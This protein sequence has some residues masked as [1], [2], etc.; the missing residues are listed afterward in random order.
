MRIGGIVATGMSNFCRWLHEWNKK[1]KAVGKAAIGLKELAWKMKWL[2]YI[3][4]ERY[5][6][7]WQWRLIQTREERR[8]WHYLEDG[9]KRFGRS[10]SQAEIEKIS[11]YE[12]RYTEFRV[13]FM[14]SH[15]TIAGLCMDY[16]FF[17]E[18]STHDD[19]HVCRLLFHDGEFD[20][21]T[22]PNM[23]LSSKF[24]EMFET[25]TRDN[26]SFWYEC[27]KGN[28]ERVIIE[29]SFTYQRRQYEE[30]YQ[31]MM[32]GKE[33]LHK[34]MFSFSKEEEIKGQE[35]LEKLGIQEPYICIFARDARY[36]ATRYKEVTWEQD[37]LDLRN[38][39]INTLKKMTQ[40]FWN[41]GIQS[42]RMGAMM[43]TTY[44]CKGAVDYT[45]VGRTEFLDAYVFSKC[46]FFIGDASGLVALPMFFKKPIGLINLQVAIYHYDNLAPM[47]IGIFLK[48]YDPIR[49]CYLR[50]KEWGV[51]FRN[52]VISNM[53]FNSYM[54]QH[55][56][57]VK[58]SS[59][60]ILDIAKELEAIHNRTMQYTEHD[61]KLQ[62]R[63]RDIVKGFQSM[64]P[65]LVN[66]YPGRIGAQWLRD[67][68]WFLE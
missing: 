14:P 50:L 2:R 16:M 18:D 21:Y 44:H 4:P 51:L 30:S 46:R 47:T 19:E 57:V 56:T 49:K 8:F 9:N 62:R 10:L 45:N 53:D 38:S 59:E 20:V 25:I 64:F 27:L 35:S 5:L 3:F 15:T 7:E 12:R 66:P 11:E 43:A 34:A 22:T 24:S 32:N 41:R 39:D 65:I 52:I 63:Y 58:N 42:I 28:R 29:T 61:E 55:Y 48:Y 26:C 31:F 1:R 6:Y 67:N 23:Y 68:E 33:I 60:E 36:N 17:S 54:Q 13:Q 40:Y 37:S